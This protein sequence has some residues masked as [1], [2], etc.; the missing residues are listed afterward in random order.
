MPGMTEGSAQVRQKPV[1][2]RSQLA[3]N[4]QAM[5]RWSD[6]GGFT[7]S[8]EHWRSIGIQ[9]AYKNRAK[10]NRLGRARDRVYEVTVSDPVPRDVI[11][12]TLYL[13]TEES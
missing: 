3:Q 13:E 11:G 12:A 10:W 1:R 6:D 5:L 8:H 9:G 4:P 2:P 7:W